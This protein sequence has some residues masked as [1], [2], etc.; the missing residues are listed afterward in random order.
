[1][2]YFSERELGARPRIEE[3]INKT[4]WGGI[5][6]MIKTRIDDNSFGYRYSEKCPDEDQICGCDRKL[7]LLALAAEVPEIIQFKANNQPSTFA[8]LDLL[9]FCH[10]AVGK[11]T[12]DSYHSFYRHYHLEFNSE[13]GQIDFRDD[14]NRIFS[15]N[16]LAYELGADGKI[17]RLAPE[18]LREVLM[19]TT[20]HTGDNI[21][22]STLEVARKKY[23]DPSIDVRQESLEKLFDAW[24]R[25]KSIEDKD[26]KKSITTLINKVASETS[27]IKMIDTEANEL[28]RIGNTFNIRHSEMR[29]TPLESSEHI[30]YVF[31]RLFA[32]IRLLLL[33]TNRCK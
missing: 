7:F 6:G 30:D 32:L 33:K 26:K 14:I 16:G 20:F 27:F 31:H 21:L 9:E 17:I 1:M 22:D 28:T 5:F 19:S 13:E 12:Q 25:L 3:E 29:Q 24:E 18:V 4:T 10:R 15:S 2:V 8:I 11:P 23:I